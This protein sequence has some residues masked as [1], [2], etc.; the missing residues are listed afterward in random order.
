MGPLNLTD[1]IKIEMGPLNLTDSIKIEMG[2]LNLT[3]SIKNIDGL[4]KFNWFD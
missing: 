2:P 4:A 3:D 1:S